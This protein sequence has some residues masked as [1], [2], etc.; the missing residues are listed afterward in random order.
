MSL[1]PYSLSA[2]LWLSF[3]SSTHIKVLHV[4]FF[5]FFF[6]FP[7]YLFIHIILCCKDI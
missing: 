3:Y 4:L 7:M 2:Q 5:F 6:N 1:D